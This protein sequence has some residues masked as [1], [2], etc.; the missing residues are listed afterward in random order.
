[1]CLVIAC[2]ISFGS[3]LGFFSAVNLDLVVG[4]LMIVGFTMCLI[5]GMLYKIIPFL[6]WLHLTNAIDMRLRWQLKIPNMKKI[7][8]DDGA[9]S[10]F[11]LHF[12]AIALLLMSLVANFL[13]PI[14]AGAFLVSNLY[15][16]YN[17]IGGARVY[18]R[19]L[20]QVQAL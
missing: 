2:L 4:V 8:P 19:V 11:I 12:V 9:Q 6:I 7:I 10:Q 17:L 1:M 16:A 13:I 18:K 15:L 3:A 20:A 14:A 5:T